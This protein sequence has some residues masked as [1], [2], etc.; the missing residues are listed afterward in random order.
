MS[1]APSRCP[2]QSSLN[3]VPVRDLSD[4]TRRASPH[5]DQSRLPITASSYQTVLTHLS[6]LYKVARDSNL[7]IN[8]MGIWCLGR[9][10]SRSGFSMLGPGFEL[11]RTC[12]TGSKFSYHFSVLC[13][14]RVHLPRFTRS[15]TT[16]AHLT[17][18]TAP[19]DQALPSSH[20]HTLLARAIPCRQCPECAWSLSTAT[21]KT[22]ST[23]IT[24]E[25]V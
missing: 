18:S 16:S 15:L 25:E 17:T 24:S 14:L 8:E 21:D 5:R 3:L 22:S 9:T 1:G 4:L 7:D 13:C 20:I 6:L 11:I 23:S 12:C 2:S 10:R 19:F